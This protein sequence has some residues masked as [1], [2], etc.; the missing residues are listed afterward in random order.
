MV[1]GVEGGAVA[2]VGDPVAVSRYRSEPR[3]RR[4]SSLAL[5][6]AEQL[7]EGGDGELGG[8]VGVEVGELA[9]THVVVGG[10]VERF[11][12][13]ADGAELVAKNGE[14]VGGGG[15]GAYVG[16]VEGGLAERWVDGGEGAGGGDEG[17]GVGGVAVA[18]VVGEAEP[19][20]DGGEAEGGG[21]E[22]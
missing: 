2:E 4:Q 22:C 7:W 11:V 10:V 9:A 5:W 13:S 20:V 3:L 1:G 8:E 14:G 21:G 19:A 6:V 12:V 15:D 17:S 18:M 16:A